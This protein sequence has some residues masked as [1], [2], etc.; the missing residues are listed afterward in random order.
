[1]TWSFQSAIFADVSPEI[2][3]RGSCDGYTT[4]RRLRSNAGSFVSYWKVLWLFHFGSSKF[5][6]LQLCRYDHICQG[7]HYFFSVSPRCSGP[8]QYLFWSQKDCM[9]TLGSFLQAQCGSRLPFYCFI[10]D[11]RQLDQDKAVQLFHAFAPMLCKRP[12]KKIEETVREMSGSEFFIEEKLDGERMQLH[13]RGNE[14]LYFSRSVIFSFSGHHSQSVSG[15]ERITHICMG[16]TL[17]PE[18][19]LRL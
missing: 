12:T 10:S 17:A 5:L 11:L 7:D 18:A 15:K 16:N 2:Y 13:K 4:V 9:G 8:I 14:Y 3:S 6:R 1:M 19:W